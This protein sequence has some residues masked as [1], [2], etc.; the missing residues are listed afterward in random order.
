MPNWCNNVTTLQF[1]E[2]YEAKNFYDIVKGNMNSKEPVV[3]GILRPRPADQEQN[4]YDW[5]ILNW[6]TKWEPTVD[7]IDL[8]TDN[9]VFMVFDTAWGPPLQWYQYIEEQ[10]GIKVNATYLEWSMCFCGIW[11][12]DKEEHFDY[13]DRSLPQRLLDDYNIIENIEDMEE[14]E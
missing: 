14:E 5:N 7:W 1:K 12:W 10:Y 13:I 6:G 2:S 8:E 9:Q 3:F 11:D 4:W